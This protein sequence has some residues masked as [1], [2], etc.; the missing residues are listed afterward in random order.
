M[1][2][3]SNINQILIYTKRLELWLVENYSSTYY[4]TSFFIIRHTLFDLTFYYDDRRI[5]P[6]LYK[7]DMS[8]LENYGPDIFYSHINY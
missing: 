4:L 5:T 6:I 7:I 8:T 2:N 1:L 3:L